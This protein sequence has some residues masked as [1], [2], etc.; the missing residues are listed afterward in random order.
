M[1]TWL[2]RKEAN[3]LSLQSHS[4]GCYLLHSFIGSSLLHSGSTTSCLD[5]CCKT[6]PALFLLN[7]GWFQAHASALN[8][9]RSPTA[10]LAKC[11]SAPMHALPGC[12]TRI[13]SA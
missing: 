12:H 1:P 6:Y 4:K 7:P 13:P 9:Q 2:L 3:C 8:V 5:L 11:L 10:E